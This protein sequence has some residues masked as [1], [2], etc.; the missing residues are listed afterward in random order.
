[1]PKSELL[2][3]CGPPDSESDQVNRTWVYNNLGG[4][5]VV[6]YFY[7]NDDIERIETVFD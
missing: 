6:I 2:T 5:K 7:A 1:M 4:Q 3:H